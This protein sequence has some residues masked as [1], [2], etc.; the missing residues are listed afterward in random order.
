[1][2]LKS[3]TSI[4]VAAGTK[5]PDQYA[6]TGA[7]NG[8]NLADINFRKTQTHGSIKTGVAIGKATGDTKAD[9]K[10]AV[11]WI[12]LDGTTQDGRSIYK[13]VLIYGDTQTGNT[14]LA[15]NADVTLAGGTNVGDVKKKYEV[16][17][18]QVG[19]EQPDSTTTP[20]TSVTGLNTGQ[21]GSATAA[22]TLANNAV[23]Q[24]AMW[25]SGSWGK[26]VIGQSASAVDD[27]KIDGRVKAAEFTT[28]TEVAKVSA[29]TASGERI[30]YTAP[31]LIKGLTV[32]YTTTFKGNESTTKSDK[33]KAASNW[34][35]AYST[36]VAG[37]GLSVAH[38]EGTTGKKT[39]TAKTYTDTVTGAEATYSNFTVGYGVFKNA[40]RAHQTKDTE[41]SKYGVKYASGSWAVG[42]TVE[43]AE[44]KNEYILH[45]NKSSSTSAY[46]ASYTI[47]EG[48]S[49]Y[50]S[51][52]SNS[53]KSTDGKTTKNN[54]TIIGAKISF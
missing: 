37:V 6:G 3:E 42:Y 26:V 15:D 29:D 7:S 47:A 28:G 21:V 2:K 45:S 49:V 39:A 22:K 24:S 43:K 41:G 14:D 5:T 4:I 44:D 54:H 18:Y 20:G 19:G 46:S 10:R 17:G 8:R 40:K 35:V 23:T 50:A 13:Q 30:T 36:N 9:L 27:N 25:V 12:K 33:A 52:S 11:K 53:V 38:A 16:I 1:M 34:A 32:A 31:E 48:F 51:K